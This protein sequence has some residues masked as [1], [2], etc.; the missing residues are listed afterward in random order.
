MIIT[1]GEYDYRLNFKH[2][3]EV[4]PSS[5]VCSIERVKTGG[6][7]KESA[8]TLGSGEATCAHIDNFCRSTGRKVA[9]SRAMKSVDK[10][11][12]KGIWDGYFKQ[13]KA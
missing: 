3:R 6:S 7:F 5:T 10:A 1:N 8:E 4:E 12:R 13:V 9:L 11:L 2:I